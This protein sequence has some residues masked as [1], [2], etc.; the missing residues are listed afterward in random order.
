MTTARYIKDKTG[1]YLEF[2]GYGGGEFFDYN[3][4]D[5]CCFTEISGVMAYDAETSLIGLALDNHLRSVVLFTTTNDDLYGDQLMDL[6]HKKRL[7]KVDFQGPF[8]NA[9]SG[10]NCWLYTWHVNA[11]AWENYVRKIAAARA[12]GYR[13][14][15]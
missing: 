5:C 1:D 7:G 9:N 3:Q 4:L 12:N 14:P 13:G 6:I 11:K 2:S 8:R 15:Y 10:N